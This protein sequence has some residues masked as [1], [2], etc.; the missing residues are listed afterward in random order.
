M[1]GRRDAEGSLNEVFNIRKIFWLNVIA[2]DS[3]MRVIGVGFDDYISFRAFDLKKFGIKAVDN[4]G[5]IHYFNLHD[6]YL[7][8]NV[9]MAVLKKSC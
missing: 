5:Q 4:I 8:S 2:E 7:D 3:L 6:Y 1:D 9:T